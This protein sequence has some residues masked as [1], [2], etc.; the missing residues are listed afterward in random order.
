HSYFSAKQQAEVA[1]SASRGGTSVG[2]AGSA[3]VWHELELANGS[4]VPWTTGAALV[5]RGN[6]PLGQNMLRYTSAGA[7]SLLPVNVAVDLQGK[8]EEQE[9]E[10]QA[11]A[12]KWS[13]STYSLIR[14]HGTVTLVS[15]RKEPSAVRVTVSLGGRAE[16]ANESGRVTVNDVRA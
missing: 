14:K 4:E 7:K 12:L 9:K 1:P 6:V 15:R 8:W 11:N 10:R 2:A 5:L 13:G 16:T 3:P